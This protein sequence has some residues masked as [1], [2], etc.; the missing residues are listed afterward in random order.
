MSSRRQRKPVIIPAT[1]A[2]QPEST[3]PSVTEADHEET[4]SDGTADSD[5][6]R[7]D[8]IDGQH[9]VMTPPEILLEQNWKRYRLR[10]KKKQVCN[11]A[12]K[13]QTLPVKL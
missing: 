9:V 10:A 11:Q 2:G 5:D 1:G 6:A 13:S 7:S 8:D 12:S 4:H 3:A